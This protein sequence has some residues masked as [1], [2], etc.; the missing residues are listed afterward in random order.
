LNSL[1]NTHPERAGGVWLV[2]GQ[3]VKPISGKSIF[4]HSASEEI[5]LLEDVS[6]FFN[7]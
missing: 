7:K 1:A 4:L 5:V 2:A 6:A 3:T